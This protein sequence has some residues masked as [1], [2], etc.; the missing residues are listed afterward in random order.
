MS[1]QLQPHVSLPLCVHPAAARTTPPHLHAVIA[2]K[3]HTYAHLECDSGPFVMMLGQRGAL[4]EHYL[5]YQ[6]RRPPQTTAVT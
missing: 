2:F 6:P 4:R 3:E 1:S 5:M